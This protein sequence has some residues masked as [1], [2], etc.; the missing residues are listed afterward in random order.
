MPHQPFRFSFLDE[1]FAR[2]YDDVLRMGRIFAAFAT[3]AIIVACLGLFALSAFMT[4]QRSKEISI[5]LVMGASIRNIFGLLTGN[6]MKLVMTS[7]AIGTPIAW[8]G[9]NEWLNEFA[10]REPI[11]SSV[12]I[13]AGIFAMMIA[14]ITVSYQS[15]KA[16]MARPVENLRSD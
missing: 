11:S 12:L 9:M 8:Y 2:M 14:L 6:F 13:A 7:W 10:Y 16:A 3:L 5:R 1:R 4:E 15:I